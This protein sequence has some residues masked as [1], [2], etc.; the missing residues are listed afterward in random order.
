MSPNAM[1]LCALTHSTMPSNTFRAKEGRDKKE[2]Q[3]ITSRMIL[4]RRSYALTQAFPH[5]SPSNVP[6]L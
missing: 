1:S 3:S 2:L 6:E 4:K 5:R